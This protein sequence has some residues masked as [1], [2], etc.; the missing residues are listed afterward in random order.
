MQSIM[1]KKNE[2][3]Q[4]LDKFLA[5][6]LNEA[7]KSFF[8]KMLRKKNILL[9]GKKAA[10]NEMLAVGDEVRLFL[11]DETIAKFQNVQVRVGHRKLDILYE[12]D[13][14]ILI[15]KPAGMLSQPMD[16]SRD[17]LVEYLLGYLMDQGSVTK[18]SLQTFRPSV[19]NRLDRNT[20]GIVAAGKSLA[21][22]QELSQA[23][24]MRTLDKY[25]ICLV[26]GVV[27]EPQIICGYFVKDEAANKVQIYTEE[28]AG[29]GP[30][31]THYEPICSNGQVTL[32]RVKLVTGKTHQ[33]RA[34]LSSMG[35]GIIGDSKY[36]NPGIN[37]LFQKKYGL[38]HQLLHARELHFP[39][40][41]GAL[42]NLS[43]QT[44]TAPI[45]ESFQKILK[46]EGLEENRKYG[47][48]K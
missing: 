39:R 3:G 40:M 6:Y 19:C 43:E 24:K 36:G 13:N 5:K 23:F 16:N 4:R 45:P 42:A 17:S 48:I 47:K 14:M 8:Y 15:N 41:S 31:E 37:R 20:S 22:L 2:S 10:G 29:S 7:Q 12:D 9:N 27:R 32:L 34:H 1:I 35:H 38:H 26:E 33:I 11:A 21:G 18:E 44:Y 30:I 46:G 28:K 25:Y